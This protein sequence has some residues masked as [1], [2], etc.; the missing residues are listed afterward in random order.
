MTS[1]G[2][3]RNHTE[4]PRVRVQVVRHPLGPRLLVFGRRIHEW[5]AGVVLVVVALTLVTVGVESP[6]HVF[7]VLIA[8]GCWLIAKDWH[9][10][11]PGGLDTATWSVW[12]HPRARPLR[13]Q[14]RAAWVAPVLGGLV[15]VVAAINLASALTPSVASRLANLRGILPPGTAAAAHSVSVPVSALLLA[16]SIQVIR[17]RR[18]AWTV[19]VA[20]LIGVGVLNLAKGLD[21]EE[22][23]ISWALAVCLWAARPAFYVDTPPAAV[24][25]ALARAVPLV[26]LAASISVAAVWIARGAMHP[27]IG[28]GGTFSE[29]MHL[30]TGQS[31]P[32]AFTD[33]YSWLPGALGALGLL[34]SLAT[35]APLFRRLRAPIGVPATVALAR[36]HAILRAHGSGTLGLFTL[37]TGNE[38][39]F[40]VDGHAYLAFRVEGRVVT[41]A[42]DPVGDPAATPGLLCSLAELAERRGLQIAV[43][44]AGAGMLDL[45]RDLGLRPVYLGDEAIID[46]ADFSLEGRPIRKV[47]QSVTRL[48][49]AGYVCNV[50]RVGDLIPAE[51]A[52][53]DAISARWRRGRPER[54]FSMTLDRLAGPTQSDCLV[55]EA[56]DATG[57]VRGFLH[58]APVYRQPSMSLAFMRR[59]PDTPN[60]LVEFLVSSTVGLLR[61]RGIAEISL[62]FAT[63]GRLLRAPK[64]RRERLLGQVIRLGDRWFQIS[65]LLQFNEK[66]FPRWEPRYL[67]CEGAARAPRAGL[68]AAWLEGQLPRPR[69]RRTIPVVAPVLVGDG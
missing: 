38:Y 2:L 24:R 22:A 44:G 30:L 51:I 53:L 13:A 52:Q 8:V 47:R 40:S 12:L 54:G 28:I 16:L 42:G 11:T 1:S 36:A 27:T 62:N 17:R 21:V 34:T 41:V 64:N 15:A 55:V 63:F 48:T 68:V 46:T 59:D 61:E 10:L 37:R 19:A 20:L 26:G 69:F 5:H 32:G 60:G 57:T 67:M 45:W 58:F 3:E 65:S 25:S 33:A 31:G 39:L 56:R 49:K 35:L 23:T 43:L 4:S 66:F 7:T 18:H 6:G 50:R 9:D 29:A 14:R